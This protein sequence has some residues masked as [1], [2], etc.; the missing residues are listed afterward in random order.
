MNNEIESKG[1]VP[2]CS[3][4]DIEYMSLEYFVGRRL[5]VWILMAFQ[6][7]QISVGDQYIVEADAENM[8]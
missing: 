6:A 2:D 4:N 3:C 7:R 8:S 1:L 5:G